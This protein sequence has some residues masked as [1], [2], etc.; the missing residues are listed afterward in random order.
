MEG[1][2]QY[3]FRP[4]KKKKEKKFIKKKEKKFIKKKRKKVTLRGSTRNE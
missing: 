1:K 2:N 4:K 3:I